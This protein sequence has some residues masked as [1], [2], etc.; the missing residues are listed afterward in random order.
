MAEAPPT[1]GDAC[2]AFDALDVVIEEIADGV[3][4]VRT[5]T[6]QATIAAPTDAH[7]RALRTLA[8]DVL[9]Y[10]GEPGRV[11]HFTP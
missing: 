2:R 11:T 6:H 3:W 7:P 1:T 5:D 4:L 8:V 10:R 9:H